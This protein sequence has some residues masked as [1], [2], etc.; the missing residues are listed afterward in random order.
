MSN[1]PDSKKPLES[2][3]VFLPDS[4][5]KSPNC[6]ESKP[7]TDEEFKANYFKQ[8]KLT[9]KFT[10]KDWLALNRA[11]P[12]EFE[13]QWKDTPEGHAAAVAWSERKGRER[14]VN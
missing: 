8:R 4:V 14:S 2:L 11:V 13:P 7:Q 12:L 1:V 9:A 6:E 3:P 10:N 5:G